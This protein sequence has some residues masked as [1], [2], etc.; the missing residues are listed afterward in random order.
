MLRV[1]LVEDDAVI[2]KMLL[3]YLESTGGYDVV[4]AKTAGEAV[5]SA[6]DRFDVVLLD[7]MLP[8]VSGIDLCG[9]LRQWHSCPIIFVS[10][11]D[12]S[13][14]IVEAL[15]M[16]GDDYLVKPFD[17]RVLDAKIQANI[18]RVRMDAKKKTKNELKCKGF[19]LDAN[20]HVLLRGGQEIALVPMEFQI[21]SFLMQHPM[22][23]FT[24]S[25]LYEKVWGKPSYGDTRTVAVHI[26]N[27]RKKTEGDS[28]QARYI[29]SEW[30]LG[31]SFHPDGE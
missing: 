22:E 21:L 3:Y 14:T 4:W 8:D 24:A 5:G 30:G 7:V 19:T 20:R 9:K 27:L 29:Q 12:D 13:D 18:R 1:L 6:R 26:Y 15:A 28:S 23:H 25:E 31:Y 17:N 16:G 11:L 2:A 10:C